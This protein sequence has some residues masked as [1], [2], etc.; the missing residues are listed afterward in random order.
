VLAISLPCCASAPLPCVKAVSS[1]N[2]T[3]LVITDAQLEGD[4]AHG[5]R[6]K[7]V[8]LL[9]FHKEP[10]LNA[11]DRVDS[12]ATFWSDGPDWAVVLKES[13]V[14]PVPACPLALVTDDGE[15]VVVLGV[16]GEDLNDAALRIYR[17]R[18]HI[19]DPLRDGPDHGVLVKRVSLSEIWP[20]NRLSDVMD[21]NSGTPQW[22]AGGT[23]TFSSDSSELVHKTRWGTTVRIRMRDGAVTA[24]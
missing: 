16:H 11:K 18:D 13:D 14:R 19:G 1:S 21:F 3:F 6:A 20:A 15:F 5:Y 7:Q 10:F 2:G 23:F 12:G 8:S 24:K 9:V 4:N 22:Y 17:R